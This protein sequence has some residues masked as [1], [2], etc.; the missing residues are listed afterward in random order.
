VPLSLIS[1][2]MTDRSKVAVLVRRYGVCIS[3]H[4]ESG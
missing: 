2:L 3:I 1:G 4:S